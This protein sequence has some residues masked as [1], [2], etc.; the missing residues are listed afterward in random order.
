MKTTGKWM[1]G[2]LAGALLG[3]CA[4]Q[5]QQTANPVDPWEDFNREVFAFNQVIDTYALKPVAQGYD[6][7]TPEPVQTGV[8]NFFSNLGEIRTAL[9]SVLQWKW[10]NAGIASSRFLL[11]T[12][13][14]V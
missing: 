8:G 6:F 11:N 14:G 1:V 2:V 7:I 12:T 13:L 3:G 5:A 9:N 10:V 4:S